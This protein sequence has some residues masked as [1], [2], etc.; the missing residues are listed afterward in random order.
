MVFFNEQEK[1]NLH[2]ALDQRITTFQER[3]TELQADPELYDVFITKVAPQPQSTA[4]VDEDSVNFLNQEITNLTERNAELEQALGDART[5]LDD[6]EPVLE[7]SEKNL[8]EIDRLNDNL[9]Q[10]A[11]RINSLEAECNQLRD[12]HGDTEN[13]EATIKELTKNNNNLA[14]VID[15]LNAENTELVNALDASK[16][17]LAG[18]YDTFTRH[19]AAFLREI[20]EINDENAIGYTFHRDKETRYFVKDTTGEALSFFELTN[21]LLTCIASFVDISDEETETTDEVTG[22]HHEPNDTNNN[23]VEL[24][25]LDLTNDND[26]DSI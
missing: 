22:R 12:S 6:I 16:D 7:E 1:E 3:I 21:V 10:A 9:V 20:P 14:E 8:E 23:E 15:Q 13:L 26:A 11:T 24:D 18:V 25:D 17:G 19:V 5:R 4:F 2:Q